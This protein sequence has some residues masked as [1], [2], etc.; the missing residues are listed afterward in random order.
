MFA[1]PTACIYECVHLHTAFV[2]GMCN[3]CTLKCTDF[4]CIQYS[5]LCSEPVAV[6]TLVSSYTESQVRVVVWLQH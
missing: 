6:L 3:A 4:S 1:V 5:M 2:T